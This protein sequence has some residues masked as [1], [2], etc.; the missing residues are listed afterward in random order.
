M[1]ANHEARCTTSVPNV[2]CSRRTDT[3]S[4]FVMLFPSILH[5]SWPPYHVSPNISTRLSNVHS[6]ATVKGFWLLGI[7]TRPPTM[8]RES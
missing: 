1:A 7:I 8:S 4:G 3:D 6:H 2:R 5:H